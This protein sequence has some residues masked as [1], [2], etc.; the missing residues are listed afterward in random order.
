MNNIYKNYI[1]KKILG[2][3]ILKTPFD[4][5]V[6]DD[7]LP[8]ELANDL[9]KEF[10]FYDSDVWFNYKNK[11]EDKKVLSDW[12][13]FPEKTYQTFSFFNSNFILEALSNKFDIRLYSDYGLHGGGWHIHGNGGKLN[14]HLDYSTHPYLK[15]QRKLNLIIYLCEDW[16]EN[17]GGHFGLWS[18]DVESKK[19]GELKKEIPV[20]FNKAVIFDTTQNSWHGLSRE[21]NTPPNIYRKSLAVYFLCDPTNETD[22][23][24]RALFSPTEQQKGDK[25]IEDLI[26]Q[27]SDILK[28]KNVY[29]Q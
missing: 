4:H 24:S 10:P 16:Q 13:K 15:Q 19:S 21:V 6:I 8:I 22:T 18:H 17:H 29:I 11:I 20:G 1:I 27:R 3:D 14:P 28:S 5:C 26:F 9:N 2:A 25:A 12:R 7:F 23:R